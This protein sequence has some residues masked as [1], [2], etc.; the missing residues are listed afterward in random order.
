MTFPPQPP[1]FAIQDSDLVWQP[2]ADYGNAPGQYWMPWLRDPGSLTQ[3][4]KARSNQQ[5]SV[6]VLNEAWQSQLPGQL[7]R[8]FGPVAEDHEFWSRQVLLKGRGVPWVM[9]HT[10][11]P[12]HSLQGKLQQL[13][14]L[15]NQPLGEFLFSQPGLIRAGLEITPAGE[16]GWGRRSVFILHSKP[17]MVAEFFLP[18]LLDDVPE[19]KDAS[20]S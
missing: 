16:S 17:I 2:I 5:F 19:T 10:L 6:Q 4:L 11:I 12:K 8:E 18:A 7:R 9:A 20:A 15:S 14:E 13:L 1:V 3:L